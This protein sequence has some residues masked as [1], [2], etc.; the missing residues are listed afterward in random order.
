MKSLTRVIELL[1]L[2]FIGWSCNSNSEPSKPIKLL[3]NIYSYRSIDIEHDDLPISRD[4]GVVYTFA[5]K[6]Q[7]IF[8]ITGFTKTIYCN[9]KLA[10]VYF[11]PYDVNIEK[12]VKRLEDSLKIQIPID[13]EIIQDNLRILYSQDEIKYDLF[14]MN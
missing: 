4:M 6:D 8:G 12:V 2:I 9:G 11:Y 5:G 10:S 7:T 1:L 14:K 3:N 13:K